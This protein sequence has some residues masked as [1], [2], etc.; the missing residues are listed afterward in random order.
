MYILLYVCSCPYMFGWWWSVG[1]QEGAGNIPGHGYKWRTAGGTEEMDGSYPII[2]LL[3]YVDPNQANS[4]EENRGGYRCPE[5]IVRRA[6]YVRIYSYDGCD[7]Q[8]SST[9]VE[10]QRRRE[11]D[12]RFL[13]H[14]HTQQ[15]STHARLQHV[16]WEMIWAS[17][18]ASYWKTSALSSRRVTNVSV[19]PA[20]D[21]S[22]HFVHHFIPNVGPC[23]NSVYVRYIIPIYYV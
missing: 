8:Y 2:Y 23:I 12:L 21:T 6:S 15:A 1:R 10:Y 9:V 22:I 7:T 18:S 20:V 14:F 5:L 4:K 17:V 13:S 16:K 19:R 3:Y 11:T